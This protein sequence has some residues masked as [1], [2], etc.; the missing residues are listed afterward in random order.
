M[1]ACYG[2]WGISDLGAVPG[3]GTLAC[4]LFPSDRVKSTTQKNNSMLVA[5]GQHKLGS[6]ANVAGGFASELCP[7]VHSE[8]RSGV[9]PS[10]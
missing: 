5:G 2:L 7:R 4:R 1:G 9:L 10:D 8:E 3:S 6:S